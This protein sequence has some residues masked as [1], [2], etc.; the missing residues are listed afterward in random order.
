MRFSRLTL[1]FAVLCILAAAGAAYAG[2]AYGH[3]KHAVDTN[4][5]DPLAAKWSCDTSFDP[6]TKLATIEFT[7]D[8]LAQL[9]STAGMVNASWSNIA[10]DDDGS[11][12]D[13]LQLGLDGDPVIN[14][15]FSVTAGNAGTTFHIISGL[16]G[17]LGLANADAAATAGVTVTDSLM[18]MNGAT[19]NGLLGG[20]FYRA[21]YNG[22]STLP[23]LVNGPVVVPANGTLTVSGTD[24]WQNVGAVNSMQ[25]EFYFNLTASD[26]ASGTSSFAVVPIPEPGAMLAL[27]TGLI[28][29]AGI[30][31]RKH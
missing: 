12:I 31:R 15:S 22:A 13:N 23:D 1:M 16:L 24:P 18:T 17:P 5:S 8:N 4:N 25:S 28:G 6:A 9:L 30:A 7:I 2:N 19:A 10:I 14:L 20:K 11:M 29:F 21:T 26:L 3:L 27:L